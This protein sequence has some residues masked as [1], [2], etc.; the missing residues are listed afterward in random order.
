ML[1]A[2]ALILSSLV[3]AIPAAHA[4]AQ[5]AGEITGQV[6]DP[7]KAAISNA[8][9]TATNS[10]NGAVRKAQ[11]D[12]QGHYALTDLPVGTYSITVEH[13]GFQQLKQTGLMLNVATT[14]TLN[15]TLAVGAVSQKVVVTSEAPFIDKADA[16]TGTVL[17]NQEVGELPINGRDYARFSLLTPGAIFRS[18]FIADLTFEGLHSVHNQFSIDG[19][20]ASCVADPFMANGFERG[21]RLLT[22]S[23]DTVEQF[24]VQ[25]SG[26]SAEYGRAAGSYINIATKSGT[27]DFHGTAYDYFRNNI[28]DARNF[29]ATIGP[30]AI[31]EEHVF[32]SGLVNDFLAGMQRWV[33]RIDTVEPL[34]LTTIVGY[35][36]IPGTQGNSLEN[37]TSYQ[38]GHTMSKVKGRHALT[39][40]GGIYRIWVNTNSTAK[41]T[42]QFNSP[43]EFVNDQLSTVTIVNAT[44]GNGVRATQIGLFVNDEFQML[45]TLSLDVGLRYDIETVPHDSRYATRPY[46]TRTG[47]LGPPGDPY[48]AINNKN[49]GPRIG[50]AW[51]PKPRFV[52]RSGYGIYFQDYPVGLGLIVPGNTVPGNVTLLQQ[53]IP[54]LSYPYDPFL[55]QAAALPRPNVAGF[56]WHKPDTYANQWNLSIAAQLSRNMSLQVAYVGNHGVNLLRE[57]GIN[58]FDPTL[59]ARPNPNFGNITL[60]TNSGLSSYNALQLSFI[61]R[62]SEAGLSF[63]ANYTFGHAIDDV[64][65]PSVGPSDPQNLNNIKAERGN[66]S[67]DVRQNFTF[68]LLYD[69]PLGEGHRFLS[70]GFG[71]KL[72]SGWRVSTLGILRTGVADTVYI[73]TNTFGNGDFIDQRPDCVAGV[74]PGKNR[75]EF[76]LEFFNGFNHPEF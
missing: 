60:Q 3:V 49:F 25:T 37:N 73:G 20:D 47:T 11:T 17:D 45:P 52:I 40:G 65:D 8:V 13:E 72:F 23:L 68:N 69:V 22:G 7:S 6:L 33:S 50:I 5:T 19:I 21:A 36:V 53:Q 48:F 32:A 15:L 30:V 35:S 55:S 43:Q 44:P 59:S 76:R 64:E 27:N 63:Q 61:R 39:W 16:S 18:N 14:V 24:N 57:E 26:Y 9:V 56:P 34:P 42:M 71:G 66:S 28:L 41:P 31:H 62:A 29:F 12:S 74:D 54:N 75:L 2:L 67:G 10:A 38:Y 46:D 1:V 58:Y 70:S 51:T 4:Q